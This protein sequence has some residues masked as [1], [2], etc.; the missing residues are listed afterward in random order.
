MVFAMI[1]TQYLSTLREISCL[2]GLAFIVHPCSTSAAILAPNL[3]FVEN[4]SIGNCTKMHA[5]KHGAEAVLF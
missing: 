4:S 2:S 3:A 1:G 5:S